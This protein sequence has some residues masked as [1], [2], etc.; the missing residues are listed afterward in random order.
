MRVLFLLGWL[1]L[2]ASPLPASDA[3]PDS[4]SADLP[5]QESTT[6]EDREIIR[7]LELLELLNLL[8]DLDAV[9]A[10]EEAS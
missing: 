2:V 7:N 4:G 1:F 6:E 9:T 10:L 5:G 3:P 8:K